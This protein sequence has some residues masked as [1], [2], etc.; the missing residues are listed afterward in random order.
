MQGGINVI[1]K[2]YIILDDF[3][4]QMN[5]KNISS[6]AASTAFFLFLSL[7]PMLI[8][9]CTIIPFTHLT[10]EILTNAI[11]EIT[12][13]ILDPLMRSIISDVYD[14]SAGVLSIAAIATLWSAGKGV[15]ALIRGLNTV[16]DV[17]E[18]R[19]YFLLRT[20]ASFYTL[21]MLV[22]L[23]LSLF[24][25][26]F[27][28]VLLDMIFSKVPETRT[29][30]NFF[31]NFRF[32]AVWLVLT[33]LFTAI[34]TY[35]PNKKLKFRAQIPGAMFSAVIWNV[36]SWGF[37][38]YVEASNSASTYGSLSL[39]IIIMLWLYFC[40]YIIMIGA[41][42]NRYFGPAYKVLYQKRKEKKK[43]KGA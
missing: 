4:K 22:V 27:G 7:V 43:K 8:M 35:V 12:P 37:S 11:T 31:M 19:N 6:F 32:L 29:L 40:I 30:F 20:V 33:V 39:I 26:V 14:K 3:N 24:L 34:Y 38:I 9:I 25:N 21:V 15:L 28:N 42:I 2:L 16:N 1:R 13:D 36:F 23:L 17:E 10:E 18:K 5:R 41:E